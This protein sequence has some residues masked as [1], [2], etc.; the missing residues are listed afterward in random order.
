MKLDFSNINAMVIGDLMI[1]NYIMGISTR[2]SPE[3][4]VPVI[5][6]ND[7][8]SKCG[9]AANVWKSPSDAPRKF[10]ARHIGFSLLRPLAN[11]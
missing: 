2:M 5:L 4:P 9:G 11:G 1:D 6:P 3:A 7:T 10:I 8:F